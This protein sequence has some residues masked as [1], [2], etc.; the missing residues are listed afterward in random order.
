MFSLTNGGV[1]GSNTPMQT[2]QAV[3]NVLTQ[4]KPTPDKAAILAALALLFTA[5]DVIELRAI[6]AKG[7]KRTD[8]GYFDS[9]H[10]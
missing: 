5:D 8:A 1:P 3:R 10:W 6:H 9:A 2:S 4:P 7:R